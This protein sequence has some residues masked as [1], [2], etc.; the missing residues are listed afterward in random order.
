MYKSRSSSRWYFHFHSY[1]L[2]IYVCLYCLL[3]LVGFNS[4]VRIG[5]ILKVSVQLVPIY[6]HVLAVLIVLHAANKK[7]EENN[8]KTRQKIKKGRSKRCCRRQS[9]WLI[10]APLSHR[11]RTAITTLSLCCCSAVAP[12]SHR[13]CS[14]VAPPLSLRCRAAIAP[15][16]HQYCSTVAPL[17]SLLLLIRS[18]TAI[19][20]LLRH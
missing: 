4:L 18:R 2:T 14:A 15:L 6:F 10:I 8:I 5:Y 7:T 17:L 16:L 9:T 1:V 19:A 12:L 11:Y 3:E 13:Y 20:P